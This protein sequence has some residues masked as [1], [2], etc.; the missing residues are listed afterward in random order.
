[1]LGGVRNTDVEGLDGQ[2]SLREEEPLERS[3]KDMSV[4]R[5]PWCLS[6]LQPEGTR[7][8]HAPAPLA[9]RTRP[10][11]QQHTPCRFL[12]YGF[13]T[14][15]FCPCPRALLLHLPPFYQPAPSTCLHCS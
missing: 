10:W 14:S 12:C 9:L 13:S 6:R 15:D 4:C 8:C 3:L 11:L 7:K 5:A 1:M 2:G